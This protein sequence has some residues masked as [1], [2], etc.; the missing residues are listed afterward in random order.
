MLKISFIKLV[1]IFA[2][3]IDDTTQVLLEIFLQQDN[4]TLNF[5]L[6]CIVNS[7]QRSCNP[8]T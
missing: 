5:V 6:E 3:S 4:S 2:F 8:K 1:L 7:T